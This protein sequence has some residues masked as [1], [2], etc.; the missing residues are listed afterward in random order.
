M[1]DRTWTYRG[2]SKEPDC[3]KIARVRK[4]MFSRET[5]TGASGGAQKAEKK[6]MRRWL[7]DWQ[8]LRVETWCRNVGR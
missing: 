6:M 1:S 4:H 3:T 5:N 2:T 7:V 8:R